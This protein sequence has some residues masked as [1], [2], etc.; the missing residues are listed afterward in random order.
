MT[1]LIP[2][3][4]GKRELAPQTNSDSFYN[5]LDDFFSNDWPFRRTL[6]YDTFK[7]DVVN[8]EKNYVVEAELPGVE[9]KDINVQLNEGRL[10]ISV[11]REESSEDTSKQYIH[12]ERRYSSMSRSV[13]LED[14]QAEGILAKL[15]NGVLRIVVPKEV[16]ANHSVVVDVE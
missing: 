9:K 3:N 2:F 1:G 8:E 5:M 4:R 16:K 10:Q 6:S 11:S 7:L 14:A 13:Y 15:E 12:R